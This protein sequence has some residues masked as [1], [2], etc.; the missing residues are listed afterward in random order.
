MKHS[1]RQNEAEALY[2]QAVEAVRVQGKAMT[3]LLQRKLKIGYALAAQLMDILE[4][5]GVIG[6]IGPNGAP[7]K[8]L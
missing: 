6:P 8:V 7:R 4:E 2:Q 5:K 1:S 3:S